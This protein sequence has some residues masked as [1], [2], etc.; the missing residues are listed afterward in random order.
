MFHRIN[1]RVNAQHKIQHS[2]TSHLPQSH[3]QPPRMESGPHDFRVFPLVYREE[4]ENSQATRDNRFEAWFVRPGIQLQ[5]QSL[6]NIGYAGQ[7]HVIS[8]PPHGGEPIFYTHTAQACLTAIHRSRLLHVLEWNT[9]ISRLP[10]WNI[11]HRGLALESRDTTGN[12][13]P[14]AVP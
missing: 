8:Y 13:Q 4:N 14:A 7:I 2:S 11:Q 6:I 5:I 10:I 9:D 12:Q 1:S 3:Q